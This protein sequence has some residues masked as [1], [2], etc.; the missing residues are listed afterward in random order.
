MKT[1]RPP[2]G[3]NRCGGNDLGGKQTW[4]PERY[5][6]SAAPK[7]HAAEKSF[8]GA[9]QGADPICT[10]GRPK[11]RGKKRASAPREPPG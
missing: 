6:I 2:S 1:P 10:R 5:G 11:S 4:R 9:L 7:Y 3:M 8:G